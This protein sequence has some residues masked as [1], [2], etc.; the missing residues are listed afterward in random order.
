V[1]RAQHVLSSAAK[2]RPDQEVAALISILRRERRHGDI[3]IVTSAAVERPAAEIAAL[4]D[5]LREIGS[6][7]DADKLL[8]QAGHCSAG[9]VVAIAAILAG[10][11][12]TRECRRLLHSAVTWHR[13]PAAVTALVKALSS[14]GLGQEGAR[15]MGFVAAGW[16]TGEVVALADSLR[17]AGQD[18]AA[19]PLYAAAVDLVSKR[20][21]AELASLLRA[22]RQVGQDATADQLIEAVCA[23]A[24]QPSEV[25]DLAAVLWTA[26]PDDA[27]R[28]LDTAAAMMAMTDV[29]VVAESL[30]GMDRAEA[31]LYLSSQ[32]AAQ[33][34][35]AATASLVQVLRDAGRPIDARRVLESS[36]SWPPAKTA[37]L[38]MSLRSSGSEADAD[39][40]LAASQGH[41]PDRVGE[42][43]A[44]LSAAGAEGDAAKLVGLLDVSDADQVSDV[45]S[46]LLSQNQQ[47]A[48]FAMLAWMSQRGL[49]FCCELVDA[50]SRRDM[51]NAVTLLLR[52]QAH[53]DFANVIGLLRLLR[54]RGN[55]AAL[56]EL[57]GHA[58]QRPADE[59]SG[60][61]V[62]LAAEFPDKVA[63]LLAAMKGRTTAD[64]GLVIAALPGP[65]QVAIGMLLPLL[66]D[67]RLGIVPLAAAL[68]A[69][70]PQF[71]AEFLRSI[72]R[73]YAG[74]SV[75]LGKQVVNL[76]VA[77]LANVIHLLLETVA[78]SMDARD[79]CDLFRNLEL[80]NLT[81][82]AAYLFAQ[83][84]KSPNI[85]ALTKEFKIWGYAKEVKQLRR[86]ENSR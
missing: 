83:A 64:L 29:M 62:V 35:V 69:A 79:F 53:E 22:M 24:R 45:L 40:V 8:D 31:T 43:I 67:S 27:R 21:A 39:R 77:G 5:V 37:E 10:Q 80:R 82:D 78:S 34:P 42:L 44:A 74:S 23:T 86:L 26:A 54:S 61:V 16:A 30:L 68:D 57:L 9:Q 50:L 66:P 12:R 36:Q 72:V 85:K 49:D 32:V 75:D 46:T 4:A 60:L 84:S 18:E 1:Q 56:T 41:S 52:R 63:D 20:P 51:G 70:A 38:L 2:L 15:L 19:F 71:L 81:D 25:A 33:Q 65:S 7:D 59:L 13:E 3:E 55:D 73:R 11:S 76:R 58:A 14:V 17:A 28:V 6:E 48:V 47:S